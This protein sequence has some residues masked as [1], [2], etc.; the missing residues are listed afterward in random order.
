MSFVVAL[1]DWVV[2][3]LAAKLNT[4]DLPGPPDLSGYLTE[5]D[6]GTAAAADAGDF[7]TAAQGAKADA[8]DVDQITLTG[9][10]ALTI[11]V[12]RPAGQVYRAAITQDGVG[13]HTVTFGGASVTVDTTAGA[14]TQI[15]LRPTGSGWAVAY[16][17]AA[18]TANATHLVPDPVHPGLYLM[19]SGSSLTPDP[20]HTGLYMIGA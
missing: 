10:L 5:A 3:Q 16:P 11:P 9:D 13:G 20:D 1:K 14:S 7:A 19:A 17:P 12:G 2:E 6:L 18:P 15:E 4:A 8:S